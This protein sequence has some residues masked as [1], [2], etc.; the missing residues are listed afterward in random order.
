MRRYVA[1]VSFV[2]GCAALE[3]GQHHPDDIASDAGSD[4]GSIVADAGTMTDDLSRCASDAIIV[5]QRSQLSSYG[6]PYSDAQATLENWPVSQIRPSIGVSGFGGAFKDN[7]V[8]IRVRV[9][10][11]YTGDPT[12]LGFV[13]VAEAPGEQ[14]VGTTLCFADHAC[15]FSG[16]MNAGDTA[17]A[18]DFEVAGPPM[19][20]IVNLQKGQVFWINIAHRTVDGMS[21][22]ESP[23]CGVLIDFASPNRY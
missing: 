6:T 7:V 13:R 5:T 22:C 11:S 9:P 10:T 12:H 8:T 17:P 14:A 21:S 15:D 3:G 16:C 1:A 19:P 18:I 4:A 23:T 20:G 2:A